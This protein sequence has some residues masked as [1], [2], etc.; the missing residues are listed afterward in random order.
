MKT[1]CQ[2]TASRGVVRRFENTW[3]TFFVGSH[4]VGDSLRKI[5]RRRRSIISSITTSGHLGRGRVGPARCQYEIAAGNRGRS[6]RA[7]ADIAS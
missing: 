5:G 6:S 1:E 7:D 2:F 4:H 3:A